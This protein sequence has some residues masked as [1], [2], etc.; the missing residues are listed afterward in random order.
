M[1][2]SQ[3]R[4]LTAGLGLMAAS[5]SMAQIPG[6]ALEYMLQRP[7]VTKQFDNKHFGDHLFLETGAGF[8]AIT[9]NL[10]PGVEAGFAVGD[11]MSPEHGW[12]LGLESGIYRAGDV[13]PRFVKFSPDY[14]MNITAIANRNYTTPKRFEVYGIAGADLIYAHRPGGN[15]N[16]WGAHLGLRGQ[17]AFSPYSY[18]YIEPRGGIVT[19]DLTGYNTFRRVHPV[20]SFTAGLGYRLLQA[21]QRGAIGEDAQWRFRG[22]DAM[23]FSV[24]G[25]PDFLLSN[26][27]S[28]WK[29]RGGFRAQ[30]SVG[31]WFNP[32]SAMRLTGY[33][34]IMRQPG[35]NKNKV[36]GLAA[37][38]MMN[39]N[40]AFA[41]SEYGRWWCVNAL[42]GVSY[43]FSSDRGT[44]HHFPGLGFGLQGNVYL[45]K[46]IDL[47]VEPRVDLYT[48]RFSQPLTTFKKMDIVPSLLFG[49]DY[50]YTP[51]LGHRE[52]SSEEFVNRS[53]HDNMFV[54]G[55]IGINIP[56]TRNASQDI[57]TYTRPQ[58]YLGLGKWFAPLHGARLWTEIAQ[59]QIA[60]KYAVP[61][62][63]LYTAVGLDYL[64]NFSNL[65]TGY[66][67][68]RH[69]ELIGGLG[70]NVAKREKRIGNNFGMNLSLKGVW[71]PTPL[72]GLYLEP[73]L[74]GYGKRF[75]PT[76]LNKGRIDLI[77]SLMAGAQINLNGYNRT[78][79][80]E[81]VEEDGGYRR[82][83]SVAVGLA[84]DGNHIRNTDYTCPL[85]RISYTNFFTPLS[86]WR[87]NAQV[88]AHKE[89]G[90][91]YAAGV[92]G[93]DL[94]TDL[95][96]QTYGYNPDRIVDL[97]ALA[98]LNI[99][100]DYTHG[101]TRFLADVHAGGQ[102]G[103]R[104]APH[105]RLFVEPQLAYRMSKRLKGTRFG[106]WQPSVSLG[107]DYAFKGLGGMKQ[108]DAPE[109]RRFVSVDAGTGV[110]SGTIG[111]M[112]PRGRKLTF[113]SHASAGYWLT[114]VHGFEG[115]IAATTV[116]REKKSEG[117]EQLTAINANYMMNMRAAVTG[118]S[119]DNKLFQLTG[120][121][122][123]NLTIS[124]R[125]GHETKIGVG[126]QAAM[127]LGFRV[128]PQ[129]EVYAQPEAT[130]ETKSINEYTT[131][132][133]FEGELRFTLGTK[134]Y[135]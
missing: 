6:G 17:F 24:L 133:P 115:G 79:A 52:F 125:P 98:G 16:A 23:F 128:A 120:L 111:Y 89:E 12:R 14:L 135:F 13:K 70:M 2:A 19:D 8:N 107:L 36:A 71:F 97:Y 114:G 27:V 1:K 104:V 35:E 41:G 38:Y 102:L 10:D 67:D 21:P 39:L 58:V 75:L 87:V 64:F 68:R 130:M 11:W 94:L 30:L 37:D 95:T 116:M 134:Y 69:W 86:A 118:E 66:H 72:L 40:N 131:N 29:D 83:F 25:G 92:I 123:P 33:G 124:S 44:K 48:N 113:T 108:L 22:S 103:F 74:T 57:A 82:S 99:G 55:G 105:T 5:A 117:N 77:A 93:G 85:A 43:N 18:I 84:T 80:Y 81:A 121:F 31:K 53:W 15:D 100:G 132:H 78:A 50:T 62:D 63:Y 4:L 122:G 96:A 126:L 46:G 59:T 90:R 88:V 65:L 110:Y 45:G 34:T 109:Y 42:A 119:T 47:V 26:S 106:N 61:N 129:W 127:Q 3:L 20:A 28:N 54:E 91:K 49:L 56:I 112:A 32:I 73:R 51:L 60:A 76:A 101:K 7:K 9:R